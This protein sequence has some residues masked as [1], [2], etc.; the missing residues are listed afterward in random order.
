MNVR[1]SQELKSDVRSHINSMQYKDYALQLGTTDREK[2]FCI[3]HTSA[4]FI[5]LLWGEHYHLKDLMPSKWVGD[6]MKFYRPHVVLH[7]EGSGGQKHQGFS[8]WVTGTGKCPVP[9]FVNSGAD[10]HVKEE[11]LGPEL[12]AKFNT[13]KQS[14]EIETKW[15]KICS[16]VVK[17]L[18]SAKSLN[19][20]LK[21]WP[22]LVAFIPEEYLA[23]VNAKPER[24]AERKRAEESLASI[25][26]NL[27]VTSATM[28]KLAAS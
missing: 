2:L 4:E 8:V 9:P 5:K 3:K 28:V 19:S 12:L 24:T 22:E 11:D 10:F 1:I 20:A 23:R 14:R 7:V 21:S 16:D 18:E 13:Y 27:A 26:R 6:F 15:Y 25:D 17:F